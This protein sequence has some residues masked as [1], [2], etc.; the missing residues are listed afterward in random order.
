LLHIPV[1]RHVNENVVHENVRHAQ[2]C[3]E[4]VA[5]MK[6]W[7]HLVLIIVAVLLSGCPIPKHDIRFVMNGK[8]V[9]KLILPLPNSTGTV[10]LTGYTQMHALDDRTVFVLL[11]ANIAINQSTSDISF[12]PGAIRVWCRGLPLMNRLPEI[13]STTDTTHRSVEY[14]YSGDFTFE[15]VFRDSTARGHNRYFPIVC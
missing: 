8:K 13:D 1:R 4:V 15:D 12:G 2:F 3:E 6:R 5:V 11:K 7:P 10:T 9:K 14:S